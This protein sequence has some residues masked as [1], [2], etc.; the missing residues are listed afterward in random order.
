MIR[1]PSADG[2]RIKLDQCGLLFL[3]TP[4]SG[5]TRADWNGFLV[6]VA[7]TVAGVRPA[8]LDQLKSFN[9]ASV[10]DQKDFLNLKPTPPFR[11]LA[12]GCKT[13]IGRT[14]QYVNLLDA[15]SNISSC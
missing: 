6:A 1:L 7:E 4:H 14:N 2:Q 11:C 15:T 3:S 9:P 5:T 12:E 10:W 8:T 13:H